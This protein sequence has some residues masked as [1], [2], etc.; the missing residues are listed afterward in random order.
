MT[1]RHSDLLPVQTRRKYAPVIISAQRSPS[2]LSS[3][4]SQVV[5]SELSNLNG[6]TEQTSN[7]RECAGFSRIRCLNDCALP[8]RKPYREER[9]R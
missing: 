7:R 8:G 9:R 1:G 4:L 6:D 3:Q 2:R 5:G